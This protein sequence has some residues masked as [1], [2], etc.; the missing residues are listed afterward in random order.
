MPS[1]EEYLATID[2]LEHRQRIEAILIWV[3]TE[4][5]D[6]EFKIKWN[7]LVNYKRLKE[8][9]EYNIRDKADCQTFWRKA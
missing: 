2:N 7:Q 8:I 9:I 1:I 3:A 5:P 6:L 4:F